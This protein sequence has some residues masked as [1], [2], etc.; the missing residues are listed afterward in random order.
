MFNEDAFTQNRP[1]KSAMR[2]C[3][4]FDTIFSGDLKGVICML[5]LCSLNLQVTSNWHKKHNK[6]PL[7]AFSFPV[8]SES[9]LT[10]HSYQYDRCL[11][12]YQ[13]KLKCISYKNPESSGLCNRDRYILRS[14]MRRQFLKVGYI[15][16]I[17]MIIRFQ[18]R[19]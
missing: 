2:V 16:S 12:I 15:K 9:G 3:Y 13:E 19:N 6:H 10:V 8:S 17:H 4:A 5:K 7:C 18:L 1:K 11:L 14:V